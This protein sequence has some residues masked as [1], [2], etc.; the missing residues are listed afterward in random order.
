M[1]C[2]CPSKVE[3]KSLG[4]PVAGKGGVVGGAEEVIGWVKI[5]PG[6]ISIGEKSLN[7]GGTGGV[8][9]SGGMW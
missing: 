5:F 7:R 2:K 1:C 6:S 9:V 8:L 4:G 3:T